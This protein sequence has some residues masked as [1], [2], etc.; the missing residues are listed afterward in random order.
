MTKT[1]KTKLV[2]DIDKLLNINEPW[3]VL[4]ALADAY[5]AKGMKTLARKIMYIVKWLEDI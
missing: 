5:Q 2:K 4:H 3:R 1:T